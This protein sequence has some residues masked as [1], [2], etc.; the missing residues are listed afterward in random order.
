MN[1]RKLSAQIN[2]L[3]HEARAASRLLA[4]SSTE[5]KNQALLNISEALLFKQDMIL[6]SNRL[7]YEAALE[8]DPN[9]VNADRLMLNAERLAAMADGVRRIVSLND[10]IGEEFD[11]YNGDC[12]YK[13][14]IN[15][16]VPLCSNNNRIFLLQI[17]PFFSFCILF[18]RTIILL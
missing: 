6:E 12:E 5:A 9:P 14:S 2:A 13:I 11:D 1:S 18:N 10:P 3:G 16:V 15:D 8:K 17:H 7:D 4:K